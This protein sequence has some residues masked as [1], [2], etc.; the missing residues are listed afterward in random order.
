MTLPSINL[1]QHEPRQLRRQALMIT[2][3]AMV[4]VFFLWNLP[5]LGGILAPIRLFVTYVHEACHSLAALITGGKVLGFLVS[6]NGSGL[7]TTAGGSRLLIIPAGYLGAALWGS[8]MFFV[9]NRFPRYINNI[10]MALGVGMVFF[11]LLYARPDETGSPMALILGVV[12]GMLLVVAGARAPRVVTMLMLNVLALCCALEAVLDVVMLTQYIGATR[13]EVH[14]DAAAFAKEFMSLF[15]AQT[16]ATI[17]AMSWAAIAAL[18]L[19]IAMW[20]GVIKPLKRE[21][22]E[23]YDALTIRK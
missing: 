5:A 12:F 2:A 18:M 6:A 8:L 3:L 11:T 10:A 13:G 19:A 23:T 16:G 22:N 17:V 14:N 15:P 9:V 21:V 1:N 4:V 20:Y 7:A